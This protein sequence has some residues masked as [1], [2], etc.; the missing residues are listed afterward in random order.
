MDSVL[1]LRPRQHA[2]AHPGTMMSGPPK[3]MI[4]PQELVYDLDG[5]AVEEI[6]CSHAISVDKGWFSSLT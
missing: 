3:T 6:R 5:L 1:F 4:R 2:G